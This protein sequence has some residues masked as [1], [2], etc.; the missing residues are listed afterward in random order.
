MDKWVGHFRENGARGD[1]SGKLCARFPV[2]FPGG[3][4][5]NFVEYDSEHSVQSN[6][7]HD[8]LLCGTFKEIFT[9]INNLDFM[10]T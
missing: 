7:L 3:I 5:S 10:S 2:T 9:K 4:I 6:D 1:F 8:F